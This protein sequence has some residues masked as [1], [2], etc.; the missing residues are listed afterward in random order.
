MDK[1][2]EVV[3]VIITAMIVMILHEV[4]KS[5]LYCAKNKTADRNSTIWKVW[6]YIDPIGL[7]FSVTNYAGF[8][9]SYIIRVRDKVTNIWL[10]ITGYLSLLIVFITGILILR[11]QYGG[12]E[13]ILQIGTGKFSLLRY[14]GCVFWQ[15]ICLNS[16]S[17]LL[18]NLFPI[19]TFD[20][21]L[22]IAGAFPSKYMGLLQ[23]DVAYKIAII[24]LIVLDV[25]HYLSIW[26]IRFLLVIG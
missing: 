3:I 24:L 11:L 25:F 14:I 17:M 5:I 9:K 12:L 6:H 20:M 19:S 26:L 22:V 2:I 10:G 8:S 4:P 16:M 23:S 1:I 18:I 13:G 21:G 15:C 7:V